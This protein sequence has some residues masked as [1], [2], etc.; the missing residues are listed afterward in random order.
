M[1]YA[2]D[3]PKHWGKWFRD[4]ARYPVTL[5]RTVDEVHP[6]SRCFVRLDQQAQQR[7]IS[8][9]IV[10]DLAKMGCT[11]LPT[12]QEAHWYDDKA[13]QIPALRRW[14]PETHYLTDLE[15]AIAFARALRFPVISKAIDGSSS[16][17]VRVLESES[18]A[19]EEAR[20]AFGQG[21]PSVYDRRQHGYVYWQEIVKNNPGDYRVVVTGPYVWGLYRRNSKGSLFASG[22]GDNYPLTFKDPMERAAGELAV[23]ISEEIGT[24]WMAYDIVFSGNSPVVLEMSSAWTMKSYEA[25]AL[26]DRALNKTA[27]TGRDAFAVA[28]EILGGLS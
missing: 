14:L 22:S 23:E 12:V 21:F 28:A 27:R 10:F 8:R 24:S 4:A 3:D 5:F 11:T 7:E 15:Q 19:I 18:Q 1:I 2:Y 9:Q 25:C 16:K 13:A 26:F 17:C 20:L 6:G